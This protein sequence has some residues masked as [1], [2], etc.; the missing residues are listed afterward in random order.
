[1]KIAP[2][3]QDVAGGKLIMPDM[4]KCPAAL[5]E[6]R[7]LVARAAERMCEFS[8]PPRG[9]EY[10]GLPGEEARRATFR[11]LAKLERVSAKEER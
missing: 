6:L 11:A 9:G 5:R 4:T 7:A 10:S 1:M 2:T 8:I 3:L